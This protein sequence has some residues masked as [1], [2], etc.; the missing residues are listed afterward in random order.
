MPPS[1]SLTI[2]ARGMS[3]F[4]GVLIVAVLHLG[5]DVF[6]PLAL[7]AMICFVL[8]PVVDALERFNVRRIPA[9]L[10]TTAVTF[11]LI[12]AFTYLAAAQL[13]D[14]AYKLPSYQDNLRSKIVSLHLSSNGPWARVAQTMAE[15]R[16][17]LLGEGEPAPA[18]TRPKAAPL[19]PLAPEPSPAPAPAPAAAA[20]SGSGLG[21]FARSAVAV[22]LGPLGTAMI[23]AVFIVFM[24]LK[25]EDLRNRLIHLAGREHLSLTTRT[26]QDA[27]S[28]ISSYL[29][30][31]LVVNLTY[32]LPIA[33]G[34]M[35]IGV[36]N[37]LL[38]GGLTA[39]LRFIPYL[40]PWLG[41]LPPVLLS[42]A[43][44]DSWLVP[45][46]TVTLFVVVELISN[47]VIEPWLYGSS[48]GLSP[49]AILV[50]AVFWTWL[51]GAV[52]LLLATPLTVCLVVLGKNVPSLHF[53]EILLG[54]EPSLPA[55]DHYYQ[56]LLA[57]DEAEATKVLTDYCA[58]HSR[59]QALAEL[60]AA[61]ALTADREFEAGTIN[62]ET[63]SSVLARIRVHARLDPDPGDPARSLPTGA[64]VL[65]IAAEDEGDEV[66]AIILGEMLRPR[67]HAEVVSHRVLSHEKARRVVTTGA[68]V[69]CLSDTSRQ[70]APRARYL[71][72]RLRALEHGAY[73]I[74]GLWGFEMDDANPAQLAERFAVDQVTT[75]LFAA[76]DAIRRAVNQAGTLAA[77]VPEP[78]EPV[79]VPR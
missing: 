25:K 42:L 33:L 6:I 53:L 45:I 59:D 43:V 58:Q 64:D 16:K 74:A 26:L 75:S 10:A 73:V 71:G 27:S 79:L 44:S 66:L 8:A 77:T 22:V 13:L 28:R 15:L 63:Y 50:A 18:P 51:W 23:V 5:Q 54:D 67:L 31:Q 57:Q 2:L 7:A 65:L 35:L 38:W 62:A 9:V 21:E 52:G 41:A 47:N 60:L 49:V 61:A 76:R 34:L 17:E 3:I 70:D 46:L 4:I 39:V 32:G 19:P 40:G 37:A 1:R 56:R 11:A 69:V 78:A 29:L 68:P 72:R 55:P 36:P 12:A 48:T 14:L 20:N 30:M 24:L